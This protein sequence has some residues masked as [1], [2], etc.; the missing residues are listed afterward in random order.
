MMTSNKATVIGAGS[1]GTAIAGVL[2]KNGAETYLWGHHADHIES[3]KKDRQNKKYLPNFIFPINLKPT[4]DLELTVKNCGLICM[5][6]PSHGFRQVFKK[7]L[8][9]INRDVIIVS[10]VKGIENESLMTMTQLMKDELGKGSVDHDVDFSVLSGPSFAR[11]V[12][13]NTPTAVTI[14]CKNLNL[15]QKLQKVFVTDTLRV[16]ASSDIVG[17][18]ISAAF[19]N[20]IAIATGI[21]DGLGY[22]SNTRAALITRGL[23]EITRF[24]MKMGAEPATFSGLSGLGDLI[25]TCTGDLS[26]NRNVGLKLG[27][28]INLNTILAEMDMV[29][30]GVKT[31]LSGYNL[32][33]KYQVDMPILEQIY[34]IL[35]ENKDCSTAVKDLLKRELK[36]E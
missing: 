12:A 34:K 23:A 31:T 28:G 10:A 16:Y 29:A 35:Y 1:W 4:Y 17:I 11:E 8:T 33:K 7:V 5:V 21:C 14:G 36:A 19:K 13:D 15:A 3:L 25:L 18:E 26:R 2:S 27:K 6:V 30:E 22:G 32:A 24:G 20:I 9:Y